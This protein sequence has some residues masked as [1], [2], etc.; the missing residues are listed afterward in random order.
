MKEDHWKEK[1]KKNTNF[2]RHPQLIDMDHIKIS[3][4]GWKTRELLHKFA[5]IFFSGGFHSFVKSF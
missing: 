5:F 4:M 2:G 3:K 1:K